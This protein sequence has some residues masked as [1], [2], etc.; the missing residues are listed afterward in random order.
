MPKRGASFTSSRSRRL[1]PRD[2]YEPGSP[3]SGMYFNLSNGSFSTQGLASTDQSSCQRL[4]N[5][6]GRF[7]AHVVARVL[8]A[9]GAV[10]SS[11]SARA[12]SQRPKPN[13]TVAMQRAAAAL[14]RGTG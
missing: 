6:D 10:V 3:P 12:A 13:P 5:T 14:A 11:V 9:A 4:N 7:S 1:A 8:V 2:R